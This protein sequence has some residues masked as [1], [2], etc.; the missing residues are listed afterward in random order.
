[1]RAAGILALLVATDAPRR[2]AA[3]RPVAINGP[4]LREIF[5]DPHFF[6]AAPLMAACI[7]TA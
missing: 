4:R 2:P 3:A 1:M 7:N 5:G 6:A